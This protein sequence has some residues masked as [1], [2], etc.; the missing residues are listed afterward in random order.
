MQREKVIWK[1]FGKNLISFK[2]L[3][4]GEIIGTGLLNPILKRL[5]FFT[6][7]LI[8][9]NF[10][11]GYKNLGKWKGKR[12][13]NTFAPPLGSWPMVRLMV[14]A[15]KGRIVR[16]PYPVAMT[17]A[18]TYKCQCNCVH[19]SA[20]RHFRKDTSELS[21]QEAKRVIDE[22]LDLGVS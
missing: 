1:L 22:T 18:V 13:S 4:T 20:G 10:F 19:C 5:G 7:I 16:R 9:V 8:Q 21:T 6:M 11:Q 2:K 12:V 14:S 17:F 3:E 15:I